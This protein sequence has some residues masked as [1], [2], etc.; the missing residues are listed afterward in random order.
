MHIPFV[1]DRTFL[2]FA[3]FLCF[4]RYL[5][6]SL[7]WLIEPPSQFRRNTP[8][9]QS[10]KQGVLPDLDH[11]ITFDDTTQMTA[12]GGN[13]PSKK[14]AYSLPQSSAFSSSLHNQ[15]DLSFSIQEEQLPVPIITE[16]KSKE[17]A[18]TTV[19]AGGKKRPLPTPLADD[20]DEEEMLQRAGK[21]SK[22]SGNVVISQLEKTTQLKG[23]EGNGGTQ[24][25]TRKSRKAELFDDFNENDDDNDRMMDEDDQQAKKKARIDGEEG[26][27][28]KGKQVE[29]DENKVANK[30][31]QNQRQDEGEEYIPPLKLIN[32]D[33]WVDV[34]RSLGKIHL[35]DEKEKKNGTAATTTTA[36]DEEGEIIV[37]E[38]NLISPEVLSS[39]NNCSG[40]NG[41]VNG[42]GKKGMKSSFLPSSSSSS[43]NNSINGIK[44]VKK[45]IKNEIRKVNPFTKIKNNE[46]EKVLPK[47]SEREIQVVCYLFCS[48]FL[49]NTFSLILLSSLIYLIALFSFD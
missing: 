17:V 6:L 48:D 36:A 44:N 37:E 5:P 46:M 31:Q 24:A 14:G 10:L 1:L 45:F 8:G 11:D 38:R 43:S 2:L 39:L 25:T 12:A 19:A 3:V 49:V 41:D 28:I 35:K 32:A 42:K 47:E 23:L 18:S 26:A 33:D 30:Q 22:K 9:S 27:L 21:K 13:C 29:N 40:S 20:I 16:I 4:F 7:F 15:G 34:N